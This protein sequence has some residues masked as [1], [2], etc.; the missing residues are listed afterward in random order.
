[1][2]EEIPDDLMINWDQTGIKYVP[3]SNW[4]MEVK[5]AKRVEVAGVDDKRQI[6]V[7]LSC[8][9]NGKLL[10]VQVVYKGKT[11][12]CLSKVPLPSG[13][14]ITFNPNHWSNYDGISQ[15]HSQY[16]TSRKY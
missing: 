1:M 10:P 2:M 4:T 11:P 5:G 12:A 16:H 8:T 15:L 14:H 9:L 3:V 13:W 6:M 7:L